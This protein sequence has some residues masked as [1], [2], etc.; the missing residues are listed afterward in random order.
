MLTG[1]GIW[2]FGFAIARQL[3]GVRSLSWQPPV[4]WLLLRAAWPN[5][6]RPLPPAPG[7]IAGLPRQGRGAQSIY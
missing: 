1:F 2:H 5:E 3:S 4:A 7:A 6:L